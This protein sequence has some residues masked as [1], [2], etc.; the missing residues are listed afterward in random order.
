MCGGKGDSESRLGDDVNSDAW[1]EE[2]EEE[3]MQW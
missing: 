2:E 1:K 3:K